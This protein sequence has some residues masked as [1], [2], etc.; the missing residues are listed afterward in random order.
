MLWRPQRVAG[1]KAADSAASIGVETQIPC[2]LCNQVIMK[3]FTPTLLYRQSHNHYAIWCKQ[4]S[5]DTNS[6]CLRFPQDLVFIEEGFERLLLDYDRVFSCMGIPACLWRR[7]GEIYKG[8]R[9]F[10]D[11][12]GVDGFMLRDVGLRGLVHSIPLN[13]SSEKGRF[14]IYELMAE[15]SAVNYWEVRT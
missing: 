15:E 9:E 14:C 6:R 7:T 4:P 10:A 1:I 11:L 12:V 2:K 5:C 13:T 3:N 8:N